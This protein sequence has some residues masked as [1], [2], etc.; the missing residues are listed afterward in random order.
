MIWIGDKI[1]SRDWKHINSWSMNTDLFNLKKIIIIYHNF[2]CI[3]F[4]NVLKYVS[5]FL[6]VFHWQATIMGP[7]SY[8][9]FYFIIIIKKK[10]PTIVVFCRIFEVFIIFIYFSRIVHTKVACFS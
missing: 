10:D 7:V 6:L 3:W 9:K 4:K 2:I 5:F 1:E 8:Y